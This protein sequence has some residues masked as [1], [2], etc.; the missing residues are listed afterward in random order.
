[1]KKGEWEASVPTLFYMPHCDR[2]LYENVLR[3][4][5]VGALIAESEA[6]KSLADKATG[7]QSPSRSSKKQNK[8]IETSS[9]APACIRPLVIIGNS[10]S[11]YRDRFVSRSFLCAVMR[12]SKLLGV[13]A[14]EL[15]H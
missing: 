1:L 7:K 5:C 11:G 6:A 8:N 14:K 12:T 3:T 9:P 2:F 10:F 4:N 13:F 15:L